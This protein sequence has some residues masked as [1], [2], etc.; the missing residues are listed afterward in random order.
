LSSAHPV[1]A[2]DKSLKANL[3]PRYY[4]GAFAEIGAGQELVRRFFC[5]GGAAGTMNRCWTASPPIAA[6]LT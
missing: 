3:D 2:R 4:Y 1:A 6:R 5:A